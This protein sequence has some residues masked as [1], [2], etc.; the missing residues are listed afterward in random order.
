MI[1][2]NSSPHGNLSTKLSTVFASGSARCLQSSGVF[3]DVRS[4]RCLRMHQ[5]DWPKCLPAKS[6]PRNQC[7][8]GLKVA[9]RK[10][11]LVTYAQKGP[12]IENLPI[13]QKFLFNAINNF[14]VSDLKEIIFCILERHSV[15][16]KEKRGLRGVKGV[17]IHKVI[18][19]S[20]G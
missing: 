16:T 3:H 13:L 10:L 17:L 2:N 14:Q 7:S 4:R 12:T 18:H 1:P 8:R 5:Y 20:C 9:S 15:E 19:R 6:P 11:L